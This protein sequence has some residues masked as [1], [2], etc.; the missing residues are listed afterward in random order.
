[1]AKLTMKEIQD[2]AK[3]SIFNDVMAMASEQ[4]GVQFG[5]YDVAI[6]V[7]VETGEGT[8]QVY[9]T[10]SLVAKSWKDT[11]QAPAFNPIDKRDEWQADLEFKEKEKALK[12]ERSKS[13]K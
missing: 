13:K 8:Q 9:V 4:N 1:M 3:N 10:V 2:T 12:I 5:N 11:K 7:D 6:P